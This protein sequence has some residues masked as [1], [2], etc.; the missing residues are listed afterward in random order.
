[1]IPKTIILLCSGGLDSVTGL[2]DLK[3][4]GHFVSCI[5]ID[6]GQR[7]I[8]ELECARY[9][10]HRL[11]VVFTRI[12]IE[13][14]KGSTITDGTGGVVVPNRNAVF[15]SIA[16]NIAV[17]AGADTVVYCCN[18]DDESMF[19]DCRMAFVQTFNNM[20]RTAEIN[21]EVCAPYI[22]KLKWWIAGLARE[23]GVE[24]NQTWS[25]YRGG[26]A[27]C[28]ECEA[29]KKRE[30]ALVGNGEVITNGMWSGMRAKA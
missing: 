17:S 8:Q 23:L 29:C 21:V 22:D 16:V 14:L 15:L 28:G 5:G 27:P 20:L 3:N 26:A 4:Q 19:P 11:G 1:M 9:H 13:P 25:C 12:T 2:Y 10:C 7:H 24:V 6:Y 30:A 18:K